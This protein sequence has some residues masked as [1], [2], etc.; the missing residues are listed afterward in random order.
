MTR[1]G[2]CAGPGCGKDVAL[3]TGGGV[4]A[5]LHP[6]TGVECPGSHDPPVGPVPARAE[7]HSWRTVAIVLARRLEE[8]A[9][10]AAH[11]ESSP[12]PDCPFCADRAAYRVFERK[13]KAAAL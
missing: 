8:H 10:C 12:D 5:H 6:Q 3:I 13:M 4:R 9:A 11:P 7:R 1:R 2:I